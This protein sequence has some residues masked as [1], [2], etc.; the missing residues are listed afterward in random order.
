[1]NRAWGLVL[2]A[3]VLDP[4]QESGRARTRFSIGYFHHIKV[5]RVFG[6]VHV[7]PNFHVQDV[8]QGFLWNEGSDALIFLRNCTYQRTS[9]RPQFFGLGIIL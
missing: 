5:F 1:M 9:G 2:N 4:S 3:G 6:T 7:P 8:V